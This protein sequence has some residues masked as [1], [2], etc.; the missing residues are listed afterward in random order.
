MTSNFSD[1]M[2]TEMLSKGLPL[3][4]FKLTFA[5]TSVKLVLEIFY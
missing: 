2:I 4:T 3:P 5:I 1:S